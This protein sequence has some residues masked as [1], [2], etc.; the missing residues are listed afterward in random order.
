MIKILED[1]QLLKMQ[2]LPSNIVIL[3]TARCLSTVPG[4]VGNYCNSC[5]RR[6]LLQ[7]FL[8]IAVCTVHFKTHAAALNSFKLQVATSLFE[9][10]TF[11][12][13]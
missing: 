5:S 6:Q 9:W 2:R 13:L 8:R 12:H 3:H 11:S 10:S 7:I 1:V 4:T